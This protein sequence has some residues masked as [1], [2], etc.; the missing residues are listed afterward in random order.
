MPRSWAKQHATTDA[1]PQPPNRAQF[2]ARFQESYRLLWLTAVGIVREPA[3]AEDVVQEAAVIAMGKLDEF[4]SGSN[5]NAWMGQIV[6]FVALNQYRKDRNRRTDAVDP[7]TIDQRQSA[8]DAPQPSAD[9]ERLARGEL[10]PDRGGL[11]DQVM[12]ALDEIEPVARACLLL[13]TIEDLPYAE[14]ARLL[15]VPAGTA[16]SH[17]HRARQTLRERLA[18]HESAGR[19]ARSGG[20]V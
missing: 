16:M 13:R 6:R 19:S 20:T 18:S 8:D 3:K 10:P 12:Q 4:A 15:D 5:F 11:D 17:V 9:I 1:A 7:V 2:A 14:I